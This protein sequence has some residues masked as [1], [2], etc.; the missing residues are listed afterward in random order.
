MEKE[1]LEKLVS[2]NTIEDKDNKLIMNYVSEYLEKLGF[3]NHFIENNGKYNLVSFF[4]DNIEVGFSGHTDTV[5]YSNNWTFNPFELNEKDG[6][7]YGLGTCDMKGGIAAFLA[8]LSEID[9]N[10][11]NKGIGIYLTYDE[12]IGFTGIKE[13]INN[14]NVYPNLMI[15]GE[16]TNNEIIT[17][18]KGCIEYTATVYGKSAH[19]SMLN[20]GE[21]AIIKA[22]DLIND[23]RNIKFTR[24]NPLYDIPTTTMNIGT[25]N[26]GKAINIVPDLCTIRFDFRTIDNNDHEFISEK[27]KEI[28]EKYRC[29]IEKTLEIYP[30]V[31][32]SDLEFKAKA[33]NFVTES[34]FFPSKKKIILG[35]GP[36][37]PHETDENISIESLKK[38]KE[39]YKKIIEK[40]CL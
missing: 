3:K 34:G 20:K 37:N 26:G 22:M 18:T 1:I 31:N 29:K 13:I 35:V 15:V 16:P 7:L 10:K 32:D 12:E 23:L 27:L 21:N 8:A 4:K 5:G 38:C 2:F 30:L 17:A 39:Q 14:N 6:Y 40:Y 9:L 25:I 19:S 36:I 24:E 33:M 11:L 28:E